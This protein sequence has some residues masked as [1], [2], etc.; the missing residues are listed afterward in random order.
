MRR[1]PWIDCGRCGLKIKEGRGTRPGPRRRSK[2]RS[3]IKPGL[4]EESIRE[5]GDEIEIEEEDR[6]K[7]SFVTPGCQ[8]HYSRWPFGLASSPA[9]FQRMVDMLLGGMQ[10]VFAVGYIDDT[11]VYSDTWAD[12][13]AHLRQLLEALRKA[14]LE[15]HPG[16]CAFRAQEEKYLG[17]LVTRDGIRACPSKIKAILEMPRPTSAKEV[18]RF[19]GKCHYYRKFIPSFSQIAAPPFLGT[20]NT[21]RFCLDRPV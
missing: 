16:K 10:W 3:S 8:R 1:L 4:L 11:I 7:T 17:H 9:I 20:D 21:P 18:Q 12:H 13:V 15:L 19:I 5:K 14:T 6:P 2:S